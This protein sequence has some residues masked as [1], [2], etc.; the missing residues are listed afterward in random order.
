MTSRGSENYTT[1]EGIDP[2]FRSE[3]DRITK[4]F[5][6]H[7]TV[8]TTDGAEIDA[9]ML[10]EYLFRLLVGLRGVTIKQ[11]DGI[12]S[13]GIPW[14]CDRIPQGLT[15]QATTSGGSL[16]DYAEHEYDRYTVSIRFL[17]SENPNA[18]AIVFNC[19]DK[20]HNMRGFIDFVK[21][22]LNSTE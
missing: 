2:Q 11:S 22:S 10:Q 21:K 8:G 17:P 20:S 3:I 9:E 12:I 16:D 14:N 5:N 18:M 6:P 13:I 15:R 7:I 4:A 1:I 19:T